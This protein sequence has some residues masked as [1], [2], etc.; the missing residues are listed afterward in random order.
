MM[1]T[2]ALTAL[3]KL[4]LGRRSR[5]W[6]ARGCPQARRHL[7]NSAGTLRSPSLHYDLVRVGLALYGH[8]PAPHLGGSVAL[9]AGDGRSRQGDPDPRGAHRG[10]G[11]L[12]APFPDPAAESLGGGG[13]CYADGVPR[14]LSNTLTVL[15]GEKRLAQVGAITMD[16]LIIDAHRLP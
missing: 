12:R 2:P 9:E 8:C 3:Q 1:A 6:P 10:R 13:D 4:R 11:E 5:R 14:R 15:F 7:A 16:Q